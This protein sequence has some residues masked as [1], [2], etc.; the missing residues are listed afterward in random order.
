LALAARRGALDVVAWQGGL[1]DRALAV[2]R[3]VA[4]VGDG[5]P[6]IWGLAAEHVGARTEAVD[7]CHAAQHLWEQALHGRDSPDAAVAT[8]A[9]R[10]RLWEEGAGALLADWRGLPTV[11]DAQ[12]EALRLTRGYVRANAARMD[13]PAVR[14]AGLPVGFGPV[15]SAGNHLVQIRLKA[16]RRPLV[17]G[18]R[19]SP[20]RPARPR[21]FHP[22]VQRM[23]HQ[24]QKLV[25]PARVR[26]AGCL[27]AAA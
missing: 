2:L 16:P 20:L 21:S 9:W 12:A 13:V 24:P 5:A 1:R 18:R 26:V 3:P 7:F 8:A 27:P 25:T 6:W 19:P 17:R 4:V 15:E 22:A 14:A 10:H 11:T 23:T